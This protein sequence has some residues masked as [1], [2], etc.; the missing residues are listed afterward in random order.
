LRKRIMENVYYFEEK[1]RKDVIKILESE[2]DDFFKRMGFTVRE[3]DLL[4]SV[5]KGY[6]LYLKA[7]SEELDR[8]EKKLE[9]LALKKLMGEEKKIISAAFAR[10]EENAACGMGMIFG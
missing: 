9:G 2:Q 8:A 10:E 3:S 7:N 1:E 5:R 4:G 6:F